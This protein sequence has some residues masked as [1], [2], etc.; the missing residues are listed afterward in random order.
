MGFSAGEWMLQHKLA[1]A[2][3]TAMRGGGKGHRELL[4]DMLYS[5]MSP[6]SPLMD[7]CRK[8]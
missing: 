2:T 1:A 3:R 6:A 8:F 7:C 5:K 4:Q